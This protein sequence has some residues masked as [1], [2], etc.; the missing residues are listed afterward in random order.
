MN[1]CVSNRCNIKM[2]YFQHLC[3]LSFYLMILGV[4]VG[5]WKCLSHSVGLT[6]GIWI[7]DYKTTTV[8]MQK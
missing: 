8:W 4:L 1:T 3:F 6:H 2:L 7:L 5:V